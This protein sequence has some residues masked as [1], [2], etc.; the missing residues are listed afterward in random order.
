MKKMFFAAAMVVAMFTIAAPQDSRTPQASLD[1]EVDVIVPARAA[2][3]GHPH[4]A[5]APKAPP[6]C[7]PC[8][9]YAGDF[10]SNASD[11]NGLAN[12]NDVTISSGAAVYAPFNVPDVGN[13]GTVWT[14]TGLF[15]NNFLSAGV[16]DPAT[17]PYEVRR[18][19]PA[20]GGNGGFLVCHGTL[21][22]TAVATGRSDFGFNEYTVAVSGIKNCQVQGHHT[23]WLSVVP[24]CNNPNDSTCTNG[25]RGFESNDDGA[26]ANAVGMP[27]PANRSFFNSV[28]FGATWQPSS[29]QQ[30][31][32]RFS[33]GVVGTHN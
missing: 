4:K 7:K 11:A 6:Y 8:L 33:D 14:I 23:Y 18:H 13:R 15:T 27:E 28:F 2:V 26:I 29:D 12:E 19:I 25:Y 3:V 22:S 5:E 9:F 21:P 32:S 1:R 17:S 30:S 20:A 31:S 24:Y 16:L 10:D